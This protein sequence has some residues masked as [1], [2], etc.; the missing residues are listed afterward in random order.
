MANSKVNKVAV[1]GAGIA[2][3]SVAR[4]LHDT[5]VPVVVL[6]KGRRLGGRISTR[7]QHERQFDF[8][9]QYLSP[10]SRKSAV[11]FSKW[12]KADWITQWRPVAYELPERKKIDTSSW[13]VAVPSQETLAK[14][15]ADG[16]ETM[17]RTNIV[18]ISGGVGNRTLTTKTGESLGPFSVVVVA[19]SAEQAYALLEP[20]SEV[21]HLASQVQSRP[22]LATMVMFEEEVMVDFEAAFLDDH[23]LAWVALDSSKP[24]RTSQNCWVLHAN[25]DWSLENL[26]TPLER[27][28][29]E[30]LNAFAKL[31]PVE[32]PPAAYA[33]SHR[34]RYSLPKAPLELPFCFDDLI[35]IGV[36]GD[37]CNTANVDG[38]YWSGHD[39]AEAIIKS[40]SDLQVV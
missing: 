22:C 23:C 10:H 32:L 12:R 30:M 33:R 27:T 15:L 35:K 11:L 16:L 9:A 8:G 6:D 4:K 2:G 20:F 39:L 37:W 14:K 36:A 26:N 17:S 38:A 3:L 13:H 1:I 34:W 19:C 18:S 21:R 25:D 7:I 40:T 24:G 28:A 5:G 31:S 29:S